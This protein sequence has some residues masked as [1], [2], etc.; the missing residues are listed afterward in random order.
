MEKHK[1]AIILII[2]AI[3]VAFSLFSVA[4]QS[5]KQKYLDSIRVNSSTYAEYL[6][7]ENQ[8][9]IQ[10]S[11]NQ[12]STKKET[13]V[14]TPVTETIEDVQVIENNEKLE[15]QETVIEP[16]IKEEKE[17]LLQPEEQPI[18]EENLVAEN[19]DENTEDVKEE[20]KDSE[21]ETEETNTSN[22]KTTKKKTSTP[23]V[24]PEEDSSPAELIE[25]NRY[26]S[27]DSETDESNSNTEESITESND[28]NDLNDNIE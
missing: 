19:P 5:E 20:I 14:E 26:N 21:P 15:I 27:N 3:A 28:E 24:N 23:I 13:K 25:I 18:K 9:I 6:E 10:N 2:L 7:E 11:E 4:K 16:E 17:V 1:K 12:V 22:K 8:P